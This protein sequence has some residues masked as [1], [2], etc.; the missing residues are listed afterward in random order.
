MPEEY[1]I[2]P[3]CAKPTFKYDPELEANRCYS[4]YCRFNDKVLP[5]PDVPMSFLEYCLKNAKSEAH[6]SHI[7]RIIERIKQSAI[8]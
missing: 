4:E 3:V 8:A 6:A 2:C 7:K 5:A 1:K